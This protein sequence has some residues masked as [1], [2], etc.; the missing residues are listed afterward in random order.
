MKGK[1]NELDV[2]DE[3]KIFRKRKPDEKER[4]G[5]WSVAT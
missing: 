3:V 2:G 5:N 1:K 4:I